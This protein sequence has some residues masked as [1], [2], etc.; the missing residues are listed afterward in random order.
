MQSHSLRFRVDENSKVYGWVKN[1]RIMGS[2]EM[3]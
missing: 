2:E 3:S 1:N